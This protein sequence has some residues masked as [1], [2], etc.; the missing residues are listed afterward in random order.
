MARKKKGLPFVVQPR[1]KPIIEQV[2]TEESGIIEIERRGYLTVAEKAITQGGLSTDTSI[3]KMYSLAGSI[4]RETGRPQGDVAQD[5]INQ[6]RPEYLSPWN[7][8]IAEC[9]MEMIAYQERA[10]IVQA[11]ALLMSRVDTTWT[12]DQTMELHPDLLA[13]LA[14]LYSDE[15]NKTIEALVDAAEGASGGAAQGKD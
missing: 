2:G 8:E 14:E 4:A 7:D 10:A 15:E 13:G 6:E 3:R 5:L 12:V 1:L 11:T 9:I